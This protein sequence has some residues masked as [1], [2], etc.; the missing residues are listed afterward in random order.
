L[1]ITKWKIATEWSVLEDIPTPALAQLR[2]DGTG[3]AQS[4]PFIGRKVEL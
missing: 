3:F 1:I 2:P 4:L